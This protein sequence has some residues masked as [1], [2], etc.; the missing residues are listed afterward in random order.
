[1]LTLGIVILTRL[2]KGRVY[3]N[4]FTDALEATFLLNLGV[5]SAATYH[6]KLTGGNQEVLANIAVGLVFV[7]FII[8]GICHF[9]Q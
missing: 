3:K 2:L 8:I 7:T 5:F 4:W 9:I 6:N 1:M